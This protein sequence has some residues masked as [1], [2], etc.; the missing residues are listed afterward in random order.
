MKASNE[1]I[2][3]WLILLELLFGVILSIFFFKLTLYG[4]F[5]LGDDYLIEFIM[6]FALLSLL[7]FFA[8]F[9]IGIAGAIKLKQSNKIAK[10]IF[11]SLIFWVPS[12]VISIMLFDA[13]A[14][15]SLYLI[16]IGIVFG[17]N[18]GLR[19]N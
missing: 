10:A 11:Y 4:N 13:F 8:V 7:F 19:K 1:T 18:I 9:L 12:L 6:F 15:L 16:L 17:F 5:S 14:L 3:S 2:E